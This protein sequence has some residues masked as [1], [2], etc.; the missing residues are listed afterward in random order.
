MIAHGGQASES[1]RRFKALPHLEKTNIEHFLNSLVAPPEAEPEARP[2]AR[3]SVLGPSS[4]LPTGKPGT[5]ARID[6]TARAEQES[7]AESRLKLAQTLE[8]MD[9][10]QGALVFY[11][12][13]VRDEPDS[14]AAQT[15]SARIKALTGGAEGRKD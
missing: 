11:R 14:V 7:L 5:P 13:I 15:A 2:G 12:E 9:K 1:R 8:K 3:R 6:A 10:P 4:S